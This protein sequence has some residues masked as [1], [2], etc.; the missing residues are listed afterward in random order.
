MP[1]MNPSASDTSWRPLL[2]MPSVNA[3]SCWE[4]RSVMQMLS[5]GKY[6]KKGK[7][8]KDLP[9]FMVLGKGLI[10]VIVF[11]NVLDTLVVWFLSRQ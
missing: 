1:L 7:R 2:L 4:I 6:C 3:V 5:G 11:I 8:V 10:A 9:A